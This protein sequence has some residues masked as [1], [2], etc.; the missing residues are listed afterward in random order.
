MSH[1]PSP[2]EFVPVPP[3]GERTLDAA[4]PQRIFVYTPHDGAWLPKRFV[5]D[6]IERVALERRRN[7]LRDWGANRIASA[8]AAELGN[9]GYAR[10]NVSRVLLDLNR[11]P[12]TTSVAAEDPLDFFA[13]MEPFGSALAHA[14]KMALLDIYD[15]MSNAIE[16]HIAGSMISIAIHTYDA[17]NPSETK[18]PD[19]SIITTPESYLRNSRLPDGLFDPS[20]PDL[21]AESTCNRA[22]RDRISLNLERNDFRVSQNH[23]YPLPEGS[24]EVR[25]QVWSFFDFVRRR[26]EAARPEGPRDEAMQRV[27]TMLLD[28]NLRDTRSDSLRGYLHRYHRPST[29]EQA[30]VFEDCREAYARVRAFIRDTSVVREFRRAP[31]RPSNLAIEVRKDLLI[32]FDDEGAPLPVTEQQHALATTVAAVIAEA[33]EI[34]L[35][36]DR[37]T[38]AAAQR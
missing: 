24:V 38:Q 2:F 17:R 32:D 9:G 34:Y 28:T 1:P 27:W 21:L 33:I 22:L 30:A 20:Y 7:R 6:S 18:R 11:F 16:E 35:D 29:A 36:T 14:E 19:V 5:K 3:A 23:P 13:I 31:Y 15:Q 26:F 12:G 37:P 4:P 8:L 25:A 10:A